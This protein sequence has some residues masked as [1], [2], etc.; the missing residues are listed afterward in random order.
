VILAGPVIDEEEPDIED[1]VLELILIDM[2]DDFPLML[3]LML[4]LMLEFRLELELELD[5]LAL[6]AA[7]RLA[8]PPPIVEYGVHWEVAPA[9]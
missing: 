4:L 1:E 8:D 9:G 3:E 6:G 2:L 5:A 7:A